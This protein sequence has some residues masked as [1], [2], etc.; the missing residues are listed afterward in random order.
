MYKKKIKLESLVML[1]R[2]IN[3]K[4]YWRFSN[5][6]QQKAAQQSFE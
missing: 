1:Q 2:E 5:E 6:G 3:K 4:F